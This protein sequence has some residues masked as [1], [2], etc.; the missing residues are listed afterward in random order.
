MYKMISKSDAEQLFGSAEQAIKDNK[1][2]KIESDQYA[3]VDYQ[4]NGVSWHMDSIRRLS[5]REMREHDLF[6]RYRYKAHVTHAP[7]GYNG[8][9]YVNAGI[10]I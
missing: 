3:L 9:K 6:C 5:D 4:Y 1:I 2:M 7:V 10:Y 8:T